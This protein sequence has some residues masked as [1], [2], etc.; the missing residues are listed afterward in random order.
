MC[1]GLLKTVIQVLTLLLTRCV[2]LGKFLNLFD[3]QFPH[4]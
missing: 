1:F 4:L 2:T 3:L